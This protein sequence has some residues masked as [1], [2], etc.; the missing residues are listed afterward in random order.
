VS[1]DLQNKL[2]KIRL[3]LCD[4]DGVLTDSSIF[5]GSAPEQK[6]FHIR[7]GL[8]MQLLQKSGISVGWVSFRPS[9]TT[10]M[11]ADELKIDYLIQKQSSKVEGIEELLKEINLS[12]DETCFVGDDIVDLGAMK[13]AGLAVA[14][15]DGVEEAKAI[16]DYITIQPGGH[17]AVR[18][19]VELILKAKGKWQQIIDDYSK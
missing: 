18:E 11:R 4:V 17:G 13:R 16:A 12:W 7:D 5:I 2:S 15:G 1:T 10:R 9:P 6:R 14:T 3:F 19:V 8:G